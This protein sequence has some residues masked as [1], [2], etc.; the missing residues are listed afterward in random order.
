MLL[1]QLEIWENTSFLILA[2]LVIP[3]FHFFAWMEDNRLFHKQYRNV[4]KVDKD[5]MELAAEPVVT[6][7]PQASHDGKSM[8]VLDHE[9]Y[10]NESPLPQEER[11]YLQYIRN[12]KKADMRRAGPQGEN[13]TLM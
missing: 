3:Y 4:F 5:T 2:I 13:R 1:V 11:L 7:L 12:R 10:K 6:E 8:T 9:A